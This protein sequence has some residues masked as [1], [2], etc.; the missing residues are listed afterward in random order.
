MPITNIAFIFPPTLAG[1]MSRDVTVILKKRSFSVERIAD[2]LNPG[3]HY[4]GS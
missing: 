2:G 4:Q 1:R 3:A